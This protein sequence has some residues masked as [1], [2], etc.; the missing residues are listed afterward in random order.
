MGNMT[1]T[2]DFLLDLKQKLNGNLPGE[3]AHRLMLPP[4]RKLTPNS[5]NNT[6]P[7]ISAVLILLFPLNDKIHLC[8]IKRPS[9]MRNHAG[10]ISFPGGK[11][12]ATDPSIE[13]TA[14][15]EAKEEV[16][17]SPG[18]IQLIGQLSDLYI[19]VSNFLI[20][21]IIGYIEHKPHFSVNEDEVSEFF[22]IPL[23]DFSDK[24]N[25][26]MHTVNT[27]TGPLEVPCFNINNEI[28]WGA[29]AMIMAELIT[30]ISN[31]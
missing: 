12:D 2:I 1:F 15:R 25:L 18:D 20:Y 24:D 10:Q 9:T 29:T 3:K 4:N 22:T 5:T 11:H 30:I 17:I 28:I 26:K 31:N 13:Y 14:L 19:E 21:P 23:A 8:F 6:T 7:K 27:V 16:G